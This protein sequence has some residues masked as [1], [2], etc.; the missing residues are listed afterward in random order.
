MLTSIVCGPHAVV[1]INGKPFSPISAISYQISTPFKT[2]YGVD[3]ILP[4]DTVPQQVS[5]TASMQLYRVRSSGGIEGQG[6]CP[7]W[8]AATRGKYFSIIVLDRATNDILF[9]GRKNRATSQSWQIS[10]KQLVTGTVAFTGLGY[11]NNTVS[12]G[13]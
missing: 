9:E 8:E 13:T 12:P 11:N 1:Y 7:T 4:L 6:I 5:Y 2:L 3:T 10:A